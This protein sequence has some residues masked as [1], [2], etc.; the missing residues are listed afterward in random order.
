VNSTTKLYSLH[1]AANGG[2]TQSLML[3]LLKEAGIKARRAVSP[4]IGCY[5]IE[6]TGNQR[7]QTKAGRILFGA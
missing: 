4:Y 1:T 5:S 6:V 7:V 3:A 2:P